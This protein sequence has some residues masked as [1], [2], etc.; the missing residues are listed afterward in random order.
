MLVA[1]SL[2]VIVVVAVVVGAVVVILTVDDTL[3]DTLGDCAFNRYCTYSVEIRKFLDKS[4]FA[5]LGRLTCSVK[6]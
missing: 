2:V 1:A 5:F 4:M 3:D 6:S